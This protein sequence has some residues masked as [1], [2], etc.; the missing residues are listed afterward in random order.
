MKKKHLSFVLALLITFA[1]VPAM[2]VYANDAIHAPTVGSQSNM[3]DRA[4]AFQYTQSYI[5]L[6]NRRLTYAERQSWINE[7]Q[8]MGGAS[9]FEFEVVRLINEVRAAN[10][11]NVVQIDDTLMMAARFYA[12][13]KVSFSNGVGHNHGPYRIEG[14]T[15]GAS[16]EVV[17]AFGGEL[18]WNGGNSS[19][20]RW[21]P[22]A[23]VDGWMS[24]EGHR[25]YIL[26]PEH[27]FIG[28]GSQLGG[29]FGV[30]HYLFLSNQ[31][32]P[33]ANQTAINQIPA[34][35]FD[36]SQEALANS[37][38]TMDELSTMFENE[39][40]EL[41]NAERVENGLEPLYFNRALSDIYRIWAREM[42]YYGDNRGGSQSHFW[43]HD[44]RRAQTFFYDHNSPDEVIRDRLLRPLA[45]NSPG[46]YLQRR[47]IVT[48]D[49]HNASFLGRDIING[50]W[51]ATNCAG[52]ARI[53]TNA[54]VHLVIG[55]YFYEADG[56]IRNSRVHTALLSI[57]GRSTTLHNWAP[58]RLRGGVIVR[59]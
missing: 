55:V 43:L 47:P 41:I 39:L 34:I 36:W 53:Y 15:H 58:M 17:R 40:A 11:L 30:S 28:V 7:Y 3:I 42:H 18:R 48:G 4:V 5:A 22:E 27:L 29:D 52:T 24:S 9:A 37:G 44:G 45:V 10:N 2:V 26:S 8:E 54:Y 56:Y 50:Q 59:D 49:N 33:S 23:L 14:S 51:S 57:N 32:S 35:Q 38:L 16:R 6:P 25:R 1:I 12:Q 19:A 21:T 31:G 20:G 46:Q 13:I